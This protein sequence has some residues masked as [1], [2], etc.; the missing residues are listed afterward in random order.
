M[1]ELIVVFVRAV[2]FFNTLHFVVTSLRASLG[3]HI[4]L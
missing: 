2:N 4:A 1:W 3:I